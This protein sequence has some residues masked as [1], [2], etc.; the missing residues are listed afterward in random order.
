M[1]AVD[2]ATLSKLQEDL[3][4][5]PEV[6]REL[7]DTF[8]AE[9]PRLLHTMH[10]GLT[11]ARELNRAA[12]SLKSTAATFGA[13]ALSQRCRDLEAA[14]ERGVPGDAKERVAS[15]EAEWALVEADLRRLRP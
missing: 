7:L 2:A 15:V 11:N 13:M 12:H 6:M 9:V 4:G 1:T 3:G 5:D 8:F 14:S 10:V